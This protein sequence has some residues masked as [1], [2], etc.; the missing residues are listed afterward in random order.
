[1][2]KFVIIALAA[3]VSP[4]T[5]AIAQVVAPD[6]SPTTLHRSEKPAARGYASERRNTLPGMTTGSSM[7][8]GHRARSSSENAGVEQLDSTPSGD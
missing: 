6:V 8:S 4:A 2:K 7:R 5:C 1:M 3:A